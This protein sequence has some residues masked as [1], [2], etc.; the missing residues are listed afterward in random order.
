M[1]EPI[2]KTEV[3]SSSPGC[4]H[5]QLEYIDDHETVGVWI[6]VYHPTGPT[7]SS[8]QERTDRV[9]SPEMISVLRN[10]R[11]ALSGVVGGKEDAFWNIRLTYVSD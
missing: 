2:L 10:F 8:D 1:S 9:S 6:D 11:M 7:I 4:D 5:I 3:T